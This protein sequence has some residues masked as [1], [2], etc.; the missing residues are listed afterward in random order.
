MRHGRRRLEGA[1]PVP[2]RS[3]CDAGPGFRPPARPSSVL[4]GN[5]PF[6]TTTW[7]SVWTTST[8]SS[9]FAITESMHL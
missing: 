5:Y 8:R 4:L 1:T 3:E 2:W 9:W 6:T 7:R